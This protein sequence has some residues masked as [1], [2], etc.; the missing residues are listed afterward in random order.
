[1]ESDQNH[2]YPKQRVLSMIAPY[3]TWNTPDG[4]GNDFFCHAVHHPPSVGAVH[5]P[6]RSVRSGWSTIATRVVHPGDQWSSGPPVAHPKFF[7]GVIVIKPP[8]IYLSISDVMW[9]NTFILVFVASVF[10][11]HSPLFATAI[12]RFLGLCCSGQLCTAQL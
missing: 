7:F 10:Q 3:P 6:S 8:L 9:L 4:F 1:M 5:P 11:C 2:P 12:P